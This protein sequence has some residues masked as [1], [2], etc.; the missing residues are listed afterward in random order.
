[1]K[2][3]R[4]FAAGLVVSA[5]LVVAASGQAA[6]APL[7]L[8]DAVGIALEKN[9][10]RKAAVADTRVASADMETARSF[11]L[12]HLT[13]SETATRGNDPVY[14]FGSRLRQQRFTQSDFALNRLNRP[15]P[16]G[17]FATRFGGVWNLFDSFSSWHGLR[18]ARLMDEAARHQLNRTEQEV[19]FNVIRIYYQTQLAAKQLDVAEHSARTAQAI[20]ERSQARV[21]TGLVVESDL[22]TAKVRLASRQ[23]EVIRAQNDLALALSQLNAAMGVPMESSFELS[24]T[25]SEPRL[26]TLQLQDLESQALATR[27]DL[28]RT[29]AEVSAQ[30]QTVSMTRSAFGPQLNAFAG[31]ELD[32]PTFLAGG[33]GNNWVGGL[34]LK[35]DLF[36]GGA[37][38]AELSRQHALEEKAVA[39]RQAASDGVRLD[40]RRAFYDLDASRQ[41][42]EV[43]RASVAQAQESLRINQDRY[44]T[45]L[46]TVTELLG[47][48][49][50][51][52]RSQ[53]DYWNSV[54][55]LRT[56]YA[57]LELA[58]GTL[59]SQ[60]PAVMP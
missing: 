11:L 12:P 36:Q 43:A 15:L 34:E 35:I 20:V 37:K 7:T 55:Q 18:R 44:E 49:E 41:Q 31:W 13:F 60:S 14:A 10:L 2:V 59:N 33:G 40:V 48:E 57:A 19:V 30:R 23:Q 26:P 21:E 27:P 52:H 56:S 24:Q 42:L 8:H 22:L 46:I 29:T 1:M 50:A 6:P 47:A 51:T 17:N 28:K 25:L 3:R 53:T 45:G 38:R 39:M 58:T 4:Q 5:M 54:S 16:L 9:P 32:N